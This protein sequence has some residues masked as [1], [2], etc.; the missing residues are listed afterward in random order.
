MIMIFGDPY[1]FAIWVEFI[2][3]WNDTFMN[4]FFYIF[5]NGEMYPDDIRT[6]TLSVDICDIL[7]DKNPLI[8]FPANKK[9]FDMD[10]AKAFAELMDLAHP[11]ST[12]EN[13]YPEQNFDFSILTSN[14][15]SSGMTLFAVSD[16][17]NIKI[18]GAKTDKLVKEEGCDRYYWIKNEEI[19]VKEVVISNHEVK[20][21]IEK[22]K[23]YALPILQNARYTK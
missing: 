23:E 3:E 10:P 15:N 14:I 13:E 20:N 9:V 17:S 5:I 19:H 22:L 2:P 4:G 7:D 12:D 16:S 6:S 21:I 8:S 18:L 11:E 1:R